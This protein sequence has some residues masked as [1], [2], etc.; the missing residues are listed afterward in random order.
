MDSNSWKLYS[1][2]S[3]QNQYIEKACRLREQQQL[4]EMEIRRA[5]LRLIKQQQND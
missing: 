1:P 5:K 3:S 4:E 2:S